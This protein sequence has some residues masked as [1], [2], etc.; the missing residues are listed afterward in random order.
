MKNLNVI[1]VKNE[2]IGEEI[3]TIWKK[4][5]NRSAI[6]TMV[7]QFLRKENYKYWVDKSISDY[8]EN[9]NK[10]LIN[11]TYKGENKIRLSKDLISIIFSFLLEKN[12]KFAKKIKGFNFKPEKLSIKESEEKEILLFLS[13]LYQ[14]KPELILNTFYLVNSYYIE[15]YQISMRFRMNNVNSLKLASCEFE[16]NIK[17]HLLEENKS[18]VEND[19]FK[20]SIGQLIYLLNSNKE[21]INLL[22]KSYVEKKYKDMDVMK[23][24]FNNRSSFDPSIYHSSIFY[25]HLNFNGKEE[26]NRKVLMAHLISLYSASCADL[27]RYMNKSK[28]IHRYIYTGSLKCM[29]KMFLMSLF[30]HF[31]NKK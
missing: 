17:Y 15:I 6:S 30:I 14:L 24:D 23:I 18:K 5:K 3:K 1:M 2:N 20:R 25:G 9:G 13:E 29:N 4:V 31:L 12:D 11:K 28:F 19:K 7:Y 21:T 26:I 8:L 22:N 16:K 10:V 27:N